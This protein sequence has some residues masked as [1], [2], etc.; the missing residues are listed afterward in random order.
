MHDLGGFNC[1]ACVVLCYK[2]MNIMY[3]K[4]LALIF[5]E[6]RWY[7]VGEVWHLILL[8]YMG[9]SNT[10]EDGI[11]WTE[12]WCAFCRNMSLL[13]DITSIYFYPLFSC[14]RP[15]VHEKSG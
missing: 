5:H 2:S 8:G 11:A 9:C 7:Q 4:V 3:Y 12:R 14:M 10:V 1:A 6:L 13:T 15:N